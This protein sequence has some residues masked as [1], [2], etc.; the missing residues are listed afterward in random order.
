MV[1]TDENLTVLPEDL[2][3]YLD[4]LH[5][6]HVSKAG[7]GTVFPLRG[8]HQWIGGKIKGDWSEFTTAEAIE[9][10]CGLL[11]HHQ[12]VRFAGEVSGGRTRLGV[13]HDGLTE[14]GALC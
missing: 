8:R 5:R 3:P 11:S 6:T 9:Q 10:F 14:Q 7:D 2:R 12:L 1:Y 13:V 4:E